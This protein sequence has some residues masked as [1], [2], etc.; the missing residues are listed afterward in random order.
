MK[1]YFFPFSLLWATPGQR[2]FYLNSFPAFISEFKIE[3]DIEIV[4][5]FIHKKIIRQNQKKN[6]NI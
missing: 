4:N 2:L 1:K 5:L 6:M 3:E